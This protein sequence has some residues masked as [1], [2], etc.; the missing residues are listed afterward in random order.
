MFMLMEKGRIYFAA[1]RSNTN[2]HKWCVMNE[3][4]SLQV[5]SNIKFTFLHV[6]VKKTCIF[7]AKRSNTN[8]HKWCVMNELLSLQVH[9]NIKFTS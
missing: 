9:S 5:H 3:L 1:K 7:A 8:K 2:K 4:L 6:Y